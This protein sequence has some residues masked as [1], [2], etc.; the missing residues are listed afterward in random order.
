MVA[1]RGL[2]LLEEPDLAADV[3]ARLKLYD[4]AAAG[5]PVRA[6][7]NIGGASANIGT[8]AEVLK[9]RPGLVEAIAVP[10]VAERG[11]LQAMAERKVPVIHL[12]NIRGLCERY[13]ISWDP[14]PLPGP[15]A[16]SLS[17]KIPSPRR[18]TAVGTA[19]YL[20]GMLILAGGAIIARRR[21]PM[22]F[23]PV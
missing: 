7:V 8:S 9:L 4:A 6:F 11:V 1:E 15:G 12:L 17:V 20:L 18:A 13:G 23:G 14:K 5:R 3:A 2:T 22:D 21:N 16:G 19:A 10:P